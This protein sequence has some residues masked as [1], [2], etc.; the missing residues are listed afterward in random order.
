MSCIFYVLIF[1]V[2]Y[3]KALCEYFLKMCYINK[4]YLLMIL[5][6][7]IYRDYRAKMENLINEA[8]IQM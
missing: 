8:L 4:F 3:S 2:L 1:I 5:K 6:Q 7:N